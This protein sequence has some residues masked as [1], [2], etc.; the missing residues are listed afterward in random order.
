MITNLEH[1]QI[2]CHAEWSASQ[3]NSSKTVKA[4]VPLLYIAVTFPLRTTRAWTLL[5]ICHVAVI[6]DFESVKASEVAYIERM[7]HMLLR[8]TVRFTSKQLC[9][10]GITQKYKSHLNCFCMH[11]VGLCVSPHTV[12][13]SS[14]VITHSQLYHIHGL[15]MKCAK[16]NFKA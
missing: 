4:D 15:N 14:A 9:F 6:A 16:V 1:P 12:G 3:T 13:L 5:F 11:S 2:C 10:L 8:C 7:R